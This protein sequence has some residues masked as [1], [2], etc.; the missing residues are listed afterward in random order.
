M[1]LFEHNGQA[2]QVGSGHNMMKAF[3]LDNT[4]RPV[5][6]TDESGDVVAAGLG[7]ARL[8]RSKPMIKAAMREGKLL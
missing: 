4:A 2:H 7:S 5:S 3:L 8:E 6:M 1:F